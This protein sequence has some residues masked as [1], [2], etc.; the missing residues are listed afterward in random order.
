MTQSHGPM[1]RDADGRMEPCAFANPDNVLRGTPDESAFV[2]LTSADGNTMLGV[3]DCGAY[4]ERLIDY[5][6]NEMCTVIEGAVEITADGGEMVT[7]RAGDTF[8]MAKGFTGLWESHG[9]FRKF[10][11][12]SAG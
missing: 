9:R 1:T 11:M 12:I 5:A 10:F 3:W 4:A 6:Y 8:F 2:H 7:Y